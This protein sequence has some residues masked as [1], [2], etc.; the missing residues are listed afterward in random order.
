MNRR[1][2]LASAGFALA[3]SLAGCSAPRSEPPLPASAKQ[4]PV[5][6]GELSP[7]GSGGGTHE[8]YEIGSREGVADA[9]GPHAIQIMDKAGVSSVEV[10]VWD[11]LDSEVVYTRRHQIPPLQIVELHLLKP[12]TYLVRIRVESIDAVHTVRVLCEF[13]D[14]NTSGTDIGILDG[15]IKSVVWSSLAGCGEYYEC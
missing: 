9:F 12:S 7:L 4:F 6:S 2:V 5:N 14:C 10:T 8:S 11:I 1:D 13:F 3:T 15:G